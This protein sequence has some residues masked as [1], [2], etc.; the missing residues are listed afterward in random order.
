MADTR[1]RMRVLVAGSN[2]AGDHRPGDVITVD[3]PHAALFETIGFAVRVE[4][5]TD[6]ATET[7]VARRSRSRIR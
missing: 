5:A 7:A 4:A 1:V 3:E 2:D 6:A